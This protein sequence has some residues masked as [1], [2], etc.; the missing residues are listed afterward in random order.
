MTHEQTARLG[1]HLRALR[2]TYLMSPAEFAAKVG[3]KTAVLRALEGWSTPPKGYSRPQVIKQLLK[4][5]TEERRTGVPML[6]HP[7]KALECTIRDILLSFG[8]TWGSNK[9][10]VALRTAR[11]VLELGEVEMAKELEIQRGTL[12]R[13]ESFKDASQ[14]VIRPYTLACLAQFRRGPDDDPDPTRQAAI[15]NLRAVATQLSDDYYRRKYTGMGRPDLVELP[16]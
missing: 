4:F 11:A 9:L 5:C 3:I 14:V 10:T 16:Q 7:L 2:V 8:S 1:E 12:R 13:L 6:D 15:A